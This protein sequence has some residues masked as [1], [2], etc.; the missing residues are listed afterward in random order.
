MTGL[1]AAIVHARGEGLDGT[2][3]P[4]VTFLLTVVLATVG[5]RLAGL[6]RWGVAGPAGGAVTWLLIAALAVLVPTPEPELI[7][8]LPVLVVPVYVAG[9]AA[10]FALAAWSSRSP[11][12][13]W[14][15][16]LAVVVPLGSWGA[17]RHKP[18]LL[19]WLEVRGIETSGVPLIAPEIEG[20][21]LVH[22]D[23]DAAGDPEPSTWLEYWRKATPKRGFSQIQV[24]VWPA[25]AGAPRDSCL[26]VTEDFGV[27][28][29]CKQ[30]AGDRW[31][32]TGEGSS[33]V[34]LFASTGE[35]LVM[36]NASGV[37]EGDLVA[38]LPTF[39]PVTAEELAAI[40]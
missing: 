32:R 18:Q 27:P 38:V 2:L 7:G 12:R 29:R 9:G 34:T 20:Y 37:T 40:A 26:A 35:A 30:L 33:W 24:T 1:P 16:V 13:W 19:A 17:A 28:L 25:A 10:G 5:A 15:V 8:P 14:A 6:P 21:E 4:P 39:R 23:V 31:V 22:V 11:V 3:L 36:L